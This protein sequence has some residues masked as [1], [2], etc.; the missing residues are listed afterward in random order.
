MEMALGD[1][2][3]LA[4]RRNENPAKEINLTMVIGFPD[5]RRIVQ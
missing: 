4:L 5:G 2:L 1:C 3:P